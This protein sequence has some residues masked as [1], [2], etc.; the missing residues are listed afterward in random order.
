MITGLGASL[1]LA[2]PF[3]RRA[4][5]RG[6]QVIS[7]D[8]PGVASR[9]DTAGRGGCPASP[10]PSSGCWTS[11]A[12]NR[13][14]S[15]G[16]RSAVW[17]P[18]NSRTRRPTGCAVSCSR[19]P[20]PGSG[21][22]VSRVTAG[23]L[24]LATRRRY[25][26]P[27]L[28]PAGRR[29]ALRRPGPHRPGRPAARLGRPLRPSPQPGRLPRP[30]L[31]HQP[32]DRP[33]VAATAAAADARAR[34]RRRPDRPGAQRPDPGA[35]HPGRPAARRPGRRPPVPARTPGRDQPIWS[36]IS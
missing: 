29:R 12:T 30:A 3:E 36:R 32:L 35:L 18:S 25:H 6:V 34:R 20:G 24:A 7:F 31:R 26:S 9:P 28:L 16:S 15:S 2:E 19:R 17:S 1:D 4:R 8:A 27:G 21:W 22:A 11:S 13:S 10:A 33:S 5:R 14:T 23:L